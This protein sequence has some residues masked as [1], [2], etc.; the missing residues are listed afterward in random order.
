MENQAFTDKTVQDS[1]D[2]HIQHMYIILILFLRVAFRKPS[3]VAFWHKI[4][5]QPIIP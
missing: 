3:G 1:P 4:N 5:I 2:P